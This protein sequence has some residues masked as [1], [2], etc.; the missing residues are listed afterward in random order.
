MVLVSS[1]V[2]VRAS[3]R[4]LMIFLRR[5][6]EMRWPAVCTGGVH[7]SKQHEVML[8]EES[9]SV[10][11]APPIELASCGLKRIRA[12]RSALRAMLGATRR[13]RQRARRRAALAAP[14]CGMPSHL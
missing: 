5:W 8:Y 7:R 11:S 13:A 14:P 12:G 2:V 4:R 6:F 10:L 1:T 9:V 3:V